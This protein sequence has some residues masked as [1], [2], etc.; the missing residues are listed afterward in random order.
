MNTHSGHEMRNGTHLTRTVKV[1]LCAL[2]LAVSLTGCAG[3]DWASVDLD[4]GFGVGLPLLG[5]DAKAHC[6]LKL[7][8]VNNAPTPPAAPAPDRVAI[9]EL[10][11][12]IDGPSGVDRGEVGPDG[13]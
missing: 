4:T 2:V 9:D 12:A 1:R 8:K 7:G 11:V 3:S 10:R 6:K 5:V 13:I